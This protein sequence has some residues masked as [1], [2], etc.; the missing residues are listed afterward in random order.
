MEKKKSSESAEVY[1][2]TGQFFREK[3]KKVNF[4]QVGKLK[5]MCIHGASFGFFFGFFPLIH[6]RL[7]I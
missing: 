7:W 6:H 4:E 5:A 3:K 1:L 2:G